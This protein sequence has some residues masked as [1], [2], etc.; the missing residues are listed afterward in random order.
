MLASLPPPA[1]RCPFIFVRSSSAAAGLVLGFQQARYSEPDYSELGGDEDEESNTNV[2]M[3]ALLEEA[4]E[5]EAP[6]FVALSFRLPDGTR[7]SRKVHEPIAACKSDFFGAMVSTLIGTELGNP[8]PNPS[9]NPNPRIELDVGEACDDA[10]TLGTVISWMYGVDPYESEAMTIGTATKLLRLAS[11]LQMPGLVRRC[12]QDIVSW[13]TVDA[14]R[15]FDASDESMRQCTELWL[16]LSTT[17]LQGTD[18]NPSEAVRVALMRMLM[19][20]STDDPVVAYLLSSCS[21]E[22][23]ALLTTGVSCTARAID[24]ALAW[25]QQQQAHRHRDDAGDTVPAVRAV[26]AHIPLETLPACYLRSLLDSGR[27]LAGDAQLCSATLQK[28]QESEP[29]GPAGPVTTGRPA[30]RAKKAKDAKE[31]KQ[32]ETAK[33]AP[34]WVGVLNCWLSTVD[35]EPWCAGDHHLLGVRRIGC[36]GIRP[37]VEGSATTKPAAI[38]DGKALFFCGKHGMAETGY[39]RSA[40]SGD[41]SDQSPWQPFGIVPRSMVGVQYGSVVYGTWVIFVRMTGAGP[42]CVAFDVAKCTWIVMPDF[43]ARERPC[44]AVVCN[45]LYVIGGYIPGSV[46]GSETAT[47]ERIRLDQCLDAGGANVSSWACRAPRSAQWEQVQMPLARNG[48]SAVAIGTRIYVTGGYYRDIERPADCWS[49]SS[50]LTCIDTVTGTVQN[51]GSPMRTGRCGHSSFVS[52]DGKIVV[53]GGAAPRFRERIVH[54]ESFDFATM[55][56][57]PL[58][59]Q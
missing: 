40:L 11:Y 32:T 54:A 51:I 31:N 24:L 50:D 34:G 56:W 18:T 6:R 58:M 30:K 35:S 57:S 5:K 55:K 17:T 49:V 15:I 53:L 4:N 7:I 9:P 59:P 23:L 52:S 16:R 27:L 48:C 37:E 46:P 1:L 42:S 25:G 3:R 38:V 21:L 10:G 44:T 12:F 20:R 14:D 43:T 13:T 29:A 22:N 2:S 26:L 33:E 36:T 8:N 47:T 45:S 39:V 19:Q 28:A 41:Q